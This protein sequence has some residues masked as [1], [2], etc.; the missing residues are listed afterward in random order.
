MVPKTAVRAL[1]LPGSVVGPVDLGRML[2][3]LATLE[4]TLMQLRLKPDTAPRLPKTSKLLDQAIEL[5]KL[6]LLDEA[7]FI[8]L[9][10]FLSHTRECAPVLHI[11]FGA[12]P[13]AIFTQK[14]VQ[15]L[16]QEI[17]PLVLLTIGLQ[18]TIGAGCVV[19]S[20]NKY[21]D[22]S[23]REHLINNRQQLIAQLQELST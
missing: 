5:N 21:F 1:V 18:P 20:V 10:K 11:S 17:D 19:R 23:L 3:E 9:Q 7:D 2:R 15:W 12:D 13:S 16:R 4:N 8:A 22:F 6:N 14:L